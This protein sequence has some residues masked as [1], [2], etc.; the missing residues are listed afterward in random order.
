MALATQGFIELTYEEQQLSAFKNDLQKIV[1]KNIDTKV[2]PNHRLRISLS[3]RK[4]GKIL[5][6]NC[7]ITEDVAQAILESL[8]VN[9]LEDVTL[10]DA[11]LLCPIAN[12]PRQ[13]AHRDHMHGAADTFTMAIN[14]HGNALKTGIYAGSHMEEGLPTKK[15]RKDNVTIEEQR[16]TW[17]KNHEDKLHTVKTPGFLYDA[18]CVHFGAATSDDEKETLRLFMD[19]TSSKTAADIDSVST[20]TLA[21]CLPP[22]R[23]KTD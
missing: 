6:K 16:E 5:K 22:K 20:V 7:M 21:D 23:K 8:A 12:T 2:H 13:V 15:N 3:R 11:I 10:S 1:P 17:E 19:F 18:Y 14:A 4:V 9:S